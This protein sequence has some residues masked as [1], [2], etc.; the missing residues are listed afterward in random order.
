MIS[1]TYKEIMFENNHNNLWLMYKLSARYLD[2]WLIITNDPNYSPAH[3]QELV[4]NNLFQLEISLSEDHTY[5]PF[6]DIQ[7]AI[8]NDK[9]YW[10]LFRK[11][12]NAYMYPHFRSYLPKFCK[13]GIIIGETIRYFRRNKHKTDMMKELNTLKT[14]LLKRDYPIDLIDQTITST[15]KDIEK[16]KYNSKIKR[17]KKKFNNTEWIPINYIDHMKNRDILDLMDLN[18]DNETHYK[19]CFKNHRKLIQ[20]IQ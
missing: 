18:S 8:K 16:G 20:Y 12:G 19:I 11:D 15:M 10:K 14:N 3:F 7:I 17:N 2:D 5:K 4:Y 9:F 6:L 13:K 1:L